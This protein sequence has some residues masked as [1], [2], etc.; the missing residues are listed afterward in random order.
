MGF[1]GLTEA[2]PTNA[3]LLCIMKKVK[4]NWFALAIF[5]FPMLANAQG[6]WENCAIGDTCFMVPSKDTELAVSLF[7][8]ELAVKSATLVIM[9]GAGKFDRKDYAPLAQKM[10]NLGYNV[11]IFDKRGT[12][13]STGKFL[14]IHISNAEEVFTLLAA[15]VVAI[16][17][18]LKN[19]PG[20]ASDPVGLVAT[21][22]GGWI[23]PKVAQMAAEV[24]FA[25]S[26]S[27]PAVSFGEE[28]YYSKLTGD[29]KPFVEN[30]K[31][32]DFEATHQNV[33]N[34]KG[35][36]GFDPGTDLLK[37]DIP[38]LWIYGQ[39]DKS[40]PVLL[41]LE[42]IE[43]LKKDNFKVLLYPEANHSLVN[44]KTQ[45]VEDYLKEVKKWIDSI[46]FF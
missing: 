24:K 43:Q 44:V 20:I 14:E 9:H 37:L 38:V 35:R 19:I 12:G 31:A 13:Q 41:C 15:D 34:F 30:N 10:R 22:Q 2:A 11:I 5:I 25:I 17:R 27:G 26:L 3:C 33:K 39:Q 6:N 28:V 4:F 29:E 36:K 7:R 32:V 23:F 1:W 46:A 40:I 21:S 18:H 16:I 8:S 42:K 45:K